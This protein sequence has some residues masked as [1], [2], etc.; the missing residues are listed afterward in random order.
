PEFVERC[1]AGVPVLVDH[2]DTGTMRPEDHARR[3]VGATMLGWAKDDREVWCVARVYDAAVNLALAEGLLSTSPAV[4]FT[5]ADGC[6]TIELDDERRLLIEGSPTLLDHLALVPEGVW[7][8][9]V[10]SG[11]RADA[12]ETKMADENETPTETKPAPENAA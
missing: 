12:K 2:P 11:V 5:V 10:P 4:V 1:G 3:A 7:D 6:E 9:G 8:R